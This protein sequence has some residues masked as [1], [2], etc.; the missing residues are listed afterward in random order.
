M[1]RKAHDL[2]QTFTFRLALI[3]VGLFSA[4][5]VL[6][7]AFIYT[8]SINH[9]ESQIRD[10]IK[11]QYYYLSSEYRQ[12]GSASVEQRIRELIK[13]NSDSNEVYLLVDRNRNVLA[14]N[15]NEWPTKTIN[16]DTF[17]KK[18]KWV[19]FSIEDA[20]ETQEG[21][22]V[23]AL[24][25][26]LSKWRMLLVGQ[27]LQSTTKVKQ[28]IAKTFGASLALTL[29]MAFAGALVMTKSVIRRINTINRS[30]FAIMHG[31]LSAR[32][33]VQSVGDEFDNLSANL[34]AMLDKIEALMQSISQFTNNIA[35]DLRSP[36]NRIITRLDA[37]LRSID[38]K[39]PARGL[40]EKNIHDMEELISTFNAI[41][42]I[43]ELE[44]STEAKEFEEINLTEMLHNLVEL[45]EPYASERNIRLSCMIDT[46][47][48]A[49]G[50]KHLLNQAFAN[51]IDNA[52]KFS[53]DGGEIIIRAET[54]PLQIIIADS[55]PGIPEEMR[56]KVFEKFFRLE[57]SRN[58]RGNGLGLSLVA[59]IARIHAIG[60]KLED[61]KPGLRVRMIF[62]TQKKNLIYS[63][64]RTP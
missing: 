32:V 44:A 13:S 43:S 36:L 52:L 14:G 46:P 19:R 50:E 28:V 15:L 54:N 45:Y 35:H 17:D 23:R 47:Q 5:V 26:P 24:M 55:G 6:L 10:A 60:L 39:N 18:G 21:V 51:L 34:N 40:M 3:Y 42:K 64:V 20:R 37:G 2:F 8:F 11:A 4:S 27:T 9:L 29:L 57:F 30:A 33:P 41:L 12:S 62:P 31:N 49:R 53:H 22:G 48:I 1:W 61:N 63:E 59:A 56:E 16:E 58:T 7:F 25:I 38:P